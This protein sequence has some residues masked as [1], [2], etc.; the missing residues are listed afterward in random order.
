MGTFNVTCCV[1]KTPIIYDENC[2][3]VVF[4]RTNDDE[5]DYL[6]AETSSF[7][8]ESH[9]HSIYMGKY[10]GYGRLEG[11]EHPQIEDEGEYRGFF[12]SDHA[13]NLGIQ[14]VNEPEFARQMKYISK[15]FGLKNKIDKL[16]NTM[17]SCNDKLSGADEILSIAEGFSNAIGLGSSTTTASEETIKI[18]T[19]LK[20]FCLMNNLNMLDPSFENWYG[21]QSLNVEQKK[22]W[23][24]L[25]DERISILK[26]AEDE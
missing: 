3:L 24:A 22:R 17:M 23:N 7:L 13:W 2:I 18:L 6:S 16:K 21:G 19:C 25:R 4:K 9:I 10:D 8:I 11:L 5:Y 14:L 1:T 20:S 12:F 26:K 15:R